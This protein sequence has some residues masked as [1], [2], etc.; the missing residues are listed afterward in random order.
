MKYI[1][2]KSFDYYF[3]IFIIIFLIV[4]VGIQSYNYQKLNQEKDIPK[5][6]TSNDSNSANYTFEALKYIEPN[7]SETSYIQVALKVN[8][9]RFIYFSCYNSTLEINNTSIWC[10]K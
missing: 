5:F 2:V 4:I 3:A 8:E 7:Y 1:K 10:K 6:F 9:T